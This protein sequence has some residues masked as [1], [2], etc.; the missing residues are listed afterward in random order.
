MLELA[1]VKPGEMV[2]DLGAGDGRIVITAAKTYQARAVGIEIH[3]DLYRTTLER[4]K[5]LEG[6][7]EELSSEGDGETA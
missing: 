4:V 3:P 1:S 6:E 5:K 7:M 2:Y